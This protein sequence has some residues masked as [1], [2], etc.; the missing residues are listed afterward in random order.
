MSSAADQPA[1]YEIRLAG[2]LAYRWQA[3][4]DGM[5]LSHRSDGSTVI[6]GPVVDQS[7]LHGLLLVLRDIGLPLLSV[8]QV[9]PTTQPTSFREMP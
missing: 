3:R 2:H 7:A 8:T 6:S 5:T 4:F 9:E 1:F